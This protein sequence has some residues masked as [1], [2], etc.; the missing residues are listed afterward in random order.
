MLV[1]TLL[2]AAPRPA[3]TPMV[4]EQKHLT[5]NNHSTAFL[6]R[7]HLRNTSVSGSIP[8][9]WCTAQFAAELR[10]L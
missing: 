1:A 3:C 6:I 5:S 7:R 8:G 4:S 10:Q 2:W 9:Q